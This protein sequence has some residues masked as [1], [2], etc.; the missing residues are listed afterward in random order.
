MA[1]L[2]KSVRQQ[3]WARAKFRCEYCQ[4]SMRLTGM[5]LVIDHIQP[6]ILGGSDALVNLA[7]AC[8]RCNEFKGGRTS[9]VDQ[10]T[11][12]TVALYNPRSQAWSEHF[13][14]DETGIMVV[15]LTPVGQVSVMVLRLNNED[16]V[17]A[18][19]I[20]VQWGWH[21]PQDGSSITPQ[22]DRGATNKP[23]PTT[24]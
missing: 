1:G 2:S 18:R 24:P 12:E 6:Q 5:P 16:V 8:Y 23:P 22:T 14:W 4:S 21:P 19:G 9:G 20:W 15:G 3:V 13:A 7:A 17:A 10:E 11:G